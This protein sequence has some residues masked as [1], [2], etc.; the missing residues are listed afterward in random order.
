MK[1]GAIVLE[2][3]FTLAFHRWEKCLFYC[4]SHF[5][6]GS[7]LLATKCILK[8]HIGFRK[9][10]SPGSATNELLRTLFPHPQYE[11]II[12]VFL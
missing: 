6:V 12:F 2:L 3:A 1:K 9:D 10:Y 5:A 7:Q 8:V 11:E 4:L